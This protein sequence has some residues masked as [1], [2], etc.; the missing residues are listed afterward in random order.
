MPFIWLKL[1]MLFLGWFQNSK[2]KERTQQYV[3]TDEQRKMYAAEK[4]ENF[5]W[6]SKLAATYANHELSKA[7]LASEDLYKQLAELGQFA[8]LAYS[9]VSVASLLQNFT[10]L[11]QPHY[12]LEGYEALQGCIL[13]DACRGTLAELPAYVAYRPSL[14]QLVVSIAG[15]S[16]LLHALHDLRAWKTKHDSG[17][18]GVHSGFWFLYQ[19]LKQSLVSGVRKGLADHSPMEV[20]VTGH[21]MGG[22]IAYLFCIDLL[23]SD[24]ILPPNMKLTVASFGAPR[25]GD[26]QLVQYFRNLV[27]IFLGKWGVNSFQEYSVKGYNDGVPAL[28]PFTIGYRHFCLEPI[29]TI[30]GKLFRTPASDCEHALFHVQSELQTMENLRVFPK[31]GHNYY[32]GRDL[33]RFARRINWLDKSKPSEE[34]WEDRYMSFAI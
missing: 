11:S 4:L 2:A 28:P 26:K 23:S 21:S 29:Y 6:I 32:N 30:E 18:G 20:V 1:Y 15:T 7:D 31:G 24:D 8:E 25:T 12:P 19:G 3:L 22:S 14:Q 16:S 34:G 10:T 5:R 13:V 27:T 9:A 33:E 17:S